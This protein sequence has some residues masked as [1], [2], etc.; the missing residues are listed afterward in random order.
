MKLRDH[1]T[2]EFE[3]VPPPALRR[4]KRDTYLGLGVV[5]LGL[6]APR[7]LSFPWHFG[8]ALV[9]LGFFMVSRELVLGYAAALAKFV[10][11]LGGK[12]G[13]PQ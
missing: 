7:F 13:A 8:A 9:G 6:G 5:L 10:R 1:V 12:N 2:Q 3:R 11:A 4:K